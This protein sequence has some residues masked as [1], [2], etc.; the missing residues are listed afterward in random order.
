[1]A[2]EAAGRPVVAVDRDRLAARL[3]HEI[4]AFRESHPRSLE[5]S[6]RSRDSL[7]FGV[8]MS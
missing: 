3:E 8:P 5:L 1:M 7:L 4:E 2:V 6:E